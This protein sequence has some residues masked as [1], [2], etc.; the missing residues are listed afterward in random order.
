MQL[1][2]TRPNKIITCPVDDRRP[3]WVDQ[4][5]N[6]VDGHSRYL[7]HR[8]YGTPLKI[9]LLKLSPAFEVDIENLV[10]TKPKN[11]EYTSQDLEELLGIPIIIRRD[12]GTGLYVVVLG[13]T[14]IYEY[15]TRDYQTIRAKEIIAEVT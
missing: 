13:N 6:I 15:I 7:S 9:N 1:H 14:R 12:N 3:I 11:E 5:S 4:D 8:I 10:L 2:I